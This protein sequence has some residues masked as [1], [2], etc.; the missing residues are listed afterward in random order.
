MK[1]SYS[2][3]HLFLNFFLALLFISFNA[4]AQ[5][6][7]TLNWK[8]KRTNWTELD[9]KNYSE[10][11]SIIG[12]AV[13]KKECQSLDSCLDHPKNPY[14]G[15]DLKDLKIFADCAKLSYILRAY[16]AWKNSLPF[17][18]AN[19]MK[20]RDVPEN[21]GD[22]RYSRFG[23]EVTSRY[24]VVPKLRHNTYV[25][26][27]AD[28]LLQSVL[29]DSVNSANFRFFYENSDRDNLFTD[30]YPVSISRTSIKPGTVIYDPNGH[31]AIVY[32]V[33]DDGKIYFIDAHPDNSLTSGLYGTKFVRSNPAQGAGF[34]NFRPV[35]YVGGTYDPQ[36]ASYI[37]GKIQ[38]VKN[39]ELADFDLVQFFGTAR[40]PRPDW[41]KGIFSEGKQTYNYYDYVR[42]KLSK[43]DY[44]INPINE[45]NSLT[46]DLCQTAQDR[47]VAVMSAFKNG[48]TQKPHPEKLPYNIY[49]TSGE[50]EEY[51]TPS[52]DARLKTTFVELRQLVEGLYTKFTEHNPQLDYSGAD[53]KKDMLDT[54]LNVARQC[55]INYTNS[56]NISI[57]LNL[58]QIRQRL[59]NLSFDPYHCVERRWGATEPAELQSCND[60]QTDLSKTAWYQAETWLRNQIERKYDVRMD[61]SL[62]ELSQGPL[63][64][65]GV[66]TPPDI[67]LVSYL[68][69]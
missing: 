27:K 59:F 56:Q 15:S 7:D 48:I 44:K 43:G 62:T 8:I 14:K 20:L 30:Y 9:E 60:E 32:K 39:N 55:L 52:R 54:Y 58:D 34:K 24:D 17:S 51:S 40:K 4:F 38:P 28:R 5:T 21:T 11:I 1:L 19:Q 25:F 26:P 6:E 68:L 41:Q 22:K 66:T 61:Y 10:F 3:T 57:Q 45:V 16:F 53:I 37:N 50:W 64:G 67:D 31:V 12:K 36:L 23:N 35:R 2:M 13:E 47:A 42:F 69:K 33:T 49:G 29:P 65:I 18:F 63:P 46:A